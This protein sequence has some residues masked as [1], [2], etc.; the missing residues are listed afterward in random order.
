MTMISIQANAVTYDEYTRSVVV[1]AST[2]RPAGDQ[3]GIEKW[4]LVRFLTNP[5]ILFDHDPHKLP[6]GKATEVE[7]T[8]EGL[9]MRIRFATKEANPLAEQLWLCVCEQ[10]MRAVSVGYELIGA[11]EARLLEVSFVPLGLDD[12]AGTPALNPEAVLSDE[13]MSAS[14]SKAASELAKHRNRIAKQV[15]EMMK[16]EQRADNLDGPAVTAAGLVLRVDTTR[17]GK[18]ERTQIG[19]AKIHSNLS[20]TGVLTYVNPDGSKRRELRLPEEVFNKDSLRTLEH[21]P[22]I[23]IR[24]HTGMVTPDTWK[25][26]NLGH[27]VNVRQDKKFIVGEL[28]I[29][30]ADTLDAIDDGE[31]TEISL[32]YQCKLDFTKGIYE[33]EEYDCIQ[34]NIRYNHAALCPPNRG[35]AGPEVGLRLDNNAPVWGVS[36]TER[37]EKMTVKVRLDG[38]DYE[39]GTQ[40]H[41]DAVDRIH[42]VEVEKIRLDAKAEVDKALVQIT[43]LTKRADTAEG[44][45]DA[46]EGALTKERAA[47][48][49][50]KAKRAIEAKEKEKAE[51]NFIRARRRLERAT[52][53]YFGGD[54]EEDTDGE[55][56]TEKDSGGKAKSKRAMAD[57][58]M[59]AM[60]DREL[61]IHCLQKHDP[62]LTFEGK[63][64]DY[65][66]ARF[67]A[68]IDNLKAAR[69][70]NGVVNRVEALKLDAV[71]AGSEEDAMAKARKARDERAANVWKVQP[72]TNGGSR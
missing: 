42:K 30:D 54:D 17:L 58:K 56:D 38:R 12:A 49:E 1:L 24:D 2:P 3:P 50:A 39:L 11:N 5:I 67:D 66:A 35:R 21:A 14:V 65:V 31:R 6:V 62:S 32:G 26:V 33:G 63:S 41:L 7:V 61:Q 34:R 43:D 69:G 40:E 60:S 29:Q 44:R 13:E 22:V 64:D 45:A 70:V 23:D 10:I 53:R 59:D 55:K 68:C 28:L 48:E 16:T 36:Y 47:A 71:G 9:K 8:P 20:R 15:K 27:V 19:G 18:A 4:D 72:S 51:R 46:A 57:E 25:K 52:V 37:P